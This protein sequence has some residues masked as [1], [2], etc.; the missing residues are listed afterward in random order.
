[1]RK[2]RGNACG[3]GGA[4]L[5]RM[6]G[7]DSFRRLSTLNLRELRKKDLLVLVGRMLEY[8]SL[9]ID[10]SIIAESSV[11]AGYRI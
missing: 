9:N 8:S 5:N 3:S 10:T 7:K 1:M 4:I 2:E 6:I 11:S